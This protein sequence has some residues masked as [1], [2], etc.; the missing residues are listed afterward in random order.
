MELKT[1]FAVF[2]ML[3]IVFAPS[4]GTDVA[5][6]V[7]TTG[8]ITTTASDDGTA[9]VTTTDED[10]T[11]S[12]DD[13]EDETGIEVEDESSDDEGLTVLAPVLTAVTS[14]GNYG[15]CEITREGVEEYTKL[16]AVCELTLPTPCHWISY[17]WVP[18][19]DEHSYR[20][21]VVIEQQQDTCIE[22]IKTTTIEDEIYVRDVEFATHEIE[23]RQAL[24][25][26]DLQVPYEPPQEIFEVQTSSVALCTNERIRMEGELREFYLKLERVKELGDE[27]AIRDIERYIHEFKERLEDLPQFSD[28]VDL[29][30]GLAYVAEGATATQAIQ[31]LRNSERIQNKI[32]EIREIELKLRLVNPCSKLDYL[33]EN[34]EELELELE[35]TTDELTMEAIKQK[36]GMLL[37]VREHI[38]RACDVAKN[39]EVCVDAFKLRNEL[40]T[41]KDQIQSGDLGAVEIVNEIVE[42]TRAYDQYQG[43]CFNILL[44]AMEEH[45]C[46]SAQTLRIQVAKMSE[47]N[48]DADLLPH[49]YERVEE[50]E[51]KCK[52]KSQAWLNEDV[53]DFLEDELKR[54]ENF[55]TERKII[56]LRIGELELQKQFIAMD[57]AL[58]NDEKILQMGQIELKKRELIMSAIRTFGQVRV[59]A[60]MKTKFEP[61]MVDIEGQ[62]EIV[63]DISI[64]LPT[65]EDDVEGVGLVATIKKDEVELTGQ[66]S[67]VRV[68]SKM[69]F[70]NGILKF[71]NVAILLPDEIVDRARAYFGELELEEGDDGVT[72]SGPVKQK[73]RLFAIIPLSMNSHVKMDAET[74]DILSME[75]PWWAVLTVG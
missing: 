9:V 10:I 19:R 21:R 5:G 24:Q 16:K 13:L 71:G 7:N 56:A 57:E 54:S 42:L 26:I 15:A 59:S 67:I 74:G 25:P 3:S 72:Y 12:N 55:G 36:L 2:M 40:A 63:E 62:S 46:V 39:T 50:Y 4:T 11:I 51:H 28:C 66:R 58:S 75:R 20:F 17:S 68:R 18:T 45:P 34:I 6:D 38:D 31:Y 1:L 47:N 60:T 61:N 8:S 49:L 41:V 53:E 30:T 44:R 29:T 69:E 64:E 33:D 32:E 70:E 52:E 37:D 43:Q 48:E 27:G 23:Y 65:S 22:M 14:A 35:D 73:V